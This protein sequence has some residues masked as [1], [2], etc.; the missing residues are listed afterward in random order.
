[1]PPSF[2]KDVVREASKLIFL[3][4]IAIC[5]FLRSSQG[6]D[7]GAYRSI[8]EMAMKP[9]VEGDDGDQIKKAITELVITHYNLVMGRHYTIGSTT[10]VLSG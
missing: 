4:V 2:P 10:G 8:V 6:M 9:R 1:M 5:Y 7:R 3:T